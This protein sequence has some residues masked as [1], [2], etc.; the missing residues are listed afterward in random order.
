VRAQVCAIAVLGKVGVELDG[1]LT[2]HVEFGGEG[3]EVANYTLEFLCQGAVFFVESFVVVGVMG[4][5]VA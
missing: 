3:V 2:D 4:V 5:G 1:V